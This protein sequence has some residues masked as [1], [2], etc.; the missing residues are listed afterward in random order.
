MPL[1]AIGVAITSPRFLAMAFNPIALNA[2]VFALAVIAL[3]ESVDLPS[4][5]GC[6]RRPPQEAA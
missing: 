5:R 2:S 4:A 6:I 1:A 3:L